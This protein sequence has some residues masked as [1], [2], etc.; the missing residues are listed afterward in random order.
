M[1]NQS[2]FGGV[3]IGGS[4]VACA[5]GTSPINILKET[6][7]PTRSPSE[8]LPEIIQ[9][10]D[11][12]KNE[13]GNLAA[14]GVASFGP[15]DLD[16]CSQTYGQI[17]ATPKSGWVGSDVIH[18]FQNALN[19][20]VFLD[21]DVNGAAF[22][23]WLAGAGRGLNTILYMT[24]GTGIGVG[25][26]LSGQIFHGSKHPE[27]GHMRIPHDFINDPFVGICPFHGDCLEGLASGHAMELRWLS[28][29][30]NLPYNHPAWTL[31]AQYLAYATT[32]LIFA[33]SPQRIILGGGIMRHLGLLKRIQRETSKLINGYGNLGEDEIV[34]ILVEPMLGDRAGVCGAIGL[35]MQAH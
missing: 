16:P 28:R 4:K 22:G 31:E 19:I 6:I 8:T 13:Y 26:I 27:M 2:I 29:P 17:I 9:F 14:I 12:Q 1:M 30:E 24:I 33:F 35:A 32:N 7:I 18:P 25:V 3:E 23:E 10:F 20:P 5:I 34:Q 15:L 21:T 11:S